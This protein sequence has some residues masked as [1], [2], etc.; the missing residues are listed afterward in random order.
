MP[1]GVL[2]QIKG[3]EMKAEYID[4]AAQA[5]QTALCDYPAAVFDE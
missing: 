5:L 3:S 1:I 2:A 4:G